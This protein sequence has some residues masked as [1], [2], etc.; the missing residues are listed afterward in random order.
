MNQAKPIL[1]ARDYSPFISLVIPVYNES[2]AIPPFIEI[3][4]KVF[5]S[6]DLIYELVFV[7]DGSSDSTLSILVDESRRDSHI[8]IINLS[9][10]FHKE[11]ALT[12]GLD[13]VQGD[14]IVP[15]DVDLQDP[16]EIIISFLDHWRE[17]YDVVYGVRTSRKSDSLIKRL[18]ASLFYRIFNMISPDP[19]SENVGDFRLLDRAVV[20]ALKLFPERN[21]FMKGI[22]ALAGFSTKEVAYE[23]PER[24]AG[25]TKWNYWKLWN[26]ALDGVIGF[27]T[28]PLRIWLYLGI[29]ISLSAFLYASFIFFRTIILGI[30]VPGYASLMT[31]MLF[32]GGIQVLSFGVMGEYIA[33]L[34][35]EVKQ[36]PIY[37]VQ[38]IYERGEF[39]SGHQS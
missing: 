15:I 26:L 29:G 38:G 30:D 9:R 27:S 11:A 13:Y 4:N 16:P 3:I 35:I 24:S 34:F 20:N 6:R 23:R 2:E 21:R 1:R 36:R 14:V 25:K 33:R 37:I 32:L 31:V 8:R 18:T 39:K 10:N 17:G 5:G 19:L 7:N 22:F 28:L 12:A